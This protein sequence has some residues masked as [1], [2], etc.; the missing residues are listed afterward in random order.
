MPVATYEIRASE[1]E[2]ASLSTTSLEINTADNPVNEAQTW[3]DVTGGP[4]V[5]LPG[6]WLPPE[7]AT[8]FAD[9][10]NAIR[11]FENRTEDTGFPPR[12]WVDMEID[13]V[14]NLGDIGFLVM[15][16]EGVAYADIDLPLIGINPADCP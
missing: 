16:F 3:G 12:V 11:T 9:V 5:G 13:Q 15:A 4:V 1:D 10:A 7:R 8:N 14:I 6:L 2:G